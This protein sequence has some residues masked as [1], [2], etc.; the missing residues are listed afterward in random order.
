MAGALPGTP[1]GFGTVL[2]TAMRFTLAS[3]LIVA[4]WKPARWWWPTS[5]QWKPLLIVSI[6]STIGFIVQGAALAYTTAIISGFMIGLVVCFTPFFEW[7]LLKKRPTWRLVAGVACA[8]T[9]VSLMTLPG[10]GGLGFGLGEILNLVAVVAFTVQVVYT[11]V[12]ADEI[13]PARLTAGSFI[14]IAIGA[15]VTA[16]GM[17]PG[18][19]LGAM[20]VGVVSGS[21]WFYLLVTVLCATVG[22]MTLM[23]SF[24]RYVRPTEA[25]VVYTSEPVF[26]MIFALLFIGL[27]ELPGRLGL[28][29]A[30]LMLGA[31]LI[32]ALKPRRPWR[33]FDSWKKRP[34]FPRKES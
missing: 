28:F 7:I 20:R 18:S 27:T 6:P 14:I 32:V 34:G 25:A 13:G 9:G 11:G 5:S 4:L 3:T 24:Q 2:L 17:S 1:V 29:G 8:M 19:V 15:W 30:A 31:N 12:V 10:G 33:A 16:F 26:A 23:N 22:A 21:F